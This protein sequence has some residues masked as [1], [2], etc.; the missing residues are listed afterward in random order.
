V[1]GS[2]VEGVGD[3]PGSSVTDAGSMVD[4]EN[5]YNINPPNVERINKIRKIL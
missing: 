2:P 4:D 5:L 3:T 1:L